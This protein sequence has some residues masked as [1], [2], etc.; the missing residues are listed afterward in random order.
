MKHLL[1]I[2]MLSLLILI[3]QTAQAKSK[4]RYHVALVS[5]YLLRG[6]TRTQHNFA[7]QAGARLQTGNAYAGIWAS[8]V[9]VPKNSEGIP[10]E[11]DVYF[12][13]NNKFTKSF[14]LDFTVITYNY[15]NDSLADDTEFK[16]GTSPMRGLEI[17]LYRAV[18]SKMWY[19]EIRYEHFFPY[20][21]Y[22]DFSAGV[23]LPDKAEDKALNARAE[24]ARD[25]PEL[26]K[27]DVFIAIDAIT[28][29]TPFG[30]NN[31]KDE[32]EAT[33]LFGVRKKF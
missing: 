11:M 24:L 13:Y 23:W 16:I 28:D 19:P 27:I 20:R 22:A 12:G 21:I 30:N 2:S 15:L 8:N 10:A 7:G 33:F 6:I 14:N 1:A 5:D 25:F 18:K 4:T 26:A 31:D 17:N 3:P 32:S 29:T 9:Y